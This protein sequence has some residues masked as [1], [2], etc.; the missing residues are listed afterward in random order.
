MGVITLPWLE[1]SQETFEFVC[2]NANNKI[3]FTIT[4]ISKYHLP[5]TIITS[6]L[7]PYFTLELTSDI[8]AIRENNI[9]FE[10]T[11]G[12]TVE[13]CLKFIAKGYGRFVS[14]AV[15]YLD[16]FLAIPYSNL[17]FIGKCEYPTLIPSV[18]KLIFPPCKLSV[19]LVQVIQ[20]KLNILASLDTFKYEST[21]GNLKV[22]FLDLELIENDDGKETIVTAE[23]NIISEHPCVVN[24]TLKFYHDLGAACEIDLCYCYTRCGLTL[25]TNEYIPLYEHPYPYYPTTEQSD[26]Y[27][28]MNICV[29]FLE[30]WLFLQG[31]RREL[32]PIIPTTFHVISSS[33][34]SVQGG[35]PKGINVTYLNFI[36]RVAGPLMK[37]ISKVV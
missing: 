12:S 18:Y 21:D 5:V 11:R 25:H 22:T 29:E 4:N 19:E 27:D 32:F 31:F 2:S 7:A 23:I 36:R 17:T 1:F 16:K 20:M 30:R 37:H 8:E 10:L 24:S 3:E 33:L 34:T 35:K 26:L 9:K 13:F 6:K 15:M 14:V 28:Y